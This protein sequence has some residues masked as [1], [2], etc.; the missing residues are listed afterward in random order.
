MLTINL[1]LAA[2]FAPQASRAGDEPLP[3]PT[4]PH[5][6]GRVSF[7]WKDASRD[8]LET[9]APDDKRELMV[10]VFYPADPSASGAR[11]P[12]M[13]DAD[14]MRGV[15][16]DAH[17]AQVTSMRARSREG[18]ALPPGD[19]KFPV[20]IFS[21][22]GGMKGLT[23]HVLVE[24]LASHG[25]VVAAIDPPYN[26]RRVRLPDGR[27]LGNLQPADR[28]WPEPKNEEE[29][30]RYYQERIAHWSRDISFVID[31]LAA[32]DRGNGP[33]AKRL[34]L[35]RGVGVAGHSRGGQ[36][37]GTVRLLDERVRGGVNLDGAQREY[38]FMP[39]KGDDVAGAQP[40]LWIQKS[41]DPPPSEERLK[42]IGKT[43]ADYHAEVERIIAAWHR[44]LG[45]VTGGAM[46]VYIDR[47]GITHI[48]FS[49]EPFWDPMTPEVRAGKLKT[50][51]DTRAWLRAFFDGTVRGDW[52]GLKALA[53]EAGK[54]QS[55]PGSR[56]EVTVH[57]FG[58][59]WQ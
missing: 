31:Q 17:L 57:V 59:M 37:A 36:A 4:G 8:E 27:V 38:A 55:R 43:I 14:A 47:P 28:G 30:L 25:W 13:P 26:A 40:F 10:H 50:I 5:K 1:V 56:Q 22:G 20:V 11:A 29:H 21:P 16:N 15:W 45:M 52:A 58:K 3:D 7:H 19:A 49:D 53:G 48:D 35:R 23:Y 46:R 2:L 44:R 18:A 54:P 24:E 41:F 39:V 42:R 6:T 34:D 12:Y 51:A 33:F 9:K 32:L